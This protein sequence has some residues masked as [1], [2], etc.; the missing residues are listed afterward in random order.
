MNEFIKE[1]TMNSSRLMNHMNTSCDWLIK[2]FYLNLLWI[3]FT[4]AGLVIAGIFPATVAL[5]T[6]LKSF[7]TGEN[8]RVFSEF[9]DVYKKEF[10]RANRLGIVLTIL[11]IIFYTDWLF[12]NQFSGTWAMTGKG[13]LLG[14][15]FLYVITLLYVFPIFIEAERKVFPTIKIAFL[16]GIT[17][18]VHTFMMLICITSLLLTFAFLP[19]A[20][21]LFLASGLACIQSFFSPRLFKKIEA[22]AANIQKHNTKIAGYYQS[23]IREK[24]PLLKG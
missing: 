10:G 9:W 5:F 1:G 13:I 15:F 20:G 24:N 8:V 23:V 2:L 11:P 14:C 12:T 21:Y 18:P 16:I 22:Q 6:V 4:L 19:M 3:L 17:Y 7:Q